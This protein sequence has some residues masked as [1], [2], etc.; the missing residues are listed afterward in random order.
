MPPTGCRSRG[1]LLS[2]MGRFPRAGCR[3][4]RVLRADDRGGTGGR[5]ADT[6][7]GQSQSWTLAAET[8]L[9]GVELERLGFRLIYGIDL[10]EEMA[11]K[12]R[13]ALHPL[14]RQL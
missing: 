14:K 4:R 9:I 6:L 11:E 10:S 8:G 12:G 13:A 7:F 5:R 1:Q 2:R 3:P